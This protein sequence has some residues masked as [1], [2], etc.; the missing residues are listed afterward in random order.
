[1]RH[2]LQNVFSNLQRTSIS[3][4]FVTFESFANRKSEIRIFGENDLDIVGK[5]EIEKKI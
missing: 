4:S 1:M 2:F 3:N 5:I